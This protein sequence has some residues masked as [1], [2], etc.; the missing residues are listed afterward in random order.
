VDT[1]E[2]DP[3]VDWLNEYG[4]TPLSY[5]LEKVSQ[6][7][8]IIFGEVHEF[9]NYLSFLN[10]N[11]PYLYKAGVRVIAMEICRKSDDHLLNKL[12]IANNY[13]NDLALEIER[14]NLW[15]V[16]GFKDYWDILKAVWAFNSG[17]DSSQEKINIIGLETDADMPS[18]SLVLPSEDRKAGPFYEKFRIFRTAGSI[19]YV[20]YRDELMA[21][22][23]E[24]QIISKNKKGIVWVGSAHSYLNFKQPFSQKGRMA[25]IL[26]KKYGDKVYQIFLHYNDYSKQIASLLESSVQRSKFRQI[27]FDVLNSPFGILRDSSSEYFRDRPKISFSDIARGYLYLNPIDSLV[28]C[29]FIQDFVSKEM[30]INEKPFF[31]TV[32]G[33]SFKNVSELNRFYVHKFGN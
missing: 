17:L 23:I 24:D 31:E 29:K 12:V 11:I 3:Y 14:H 4:K 25:Y 20:A 32:A 22:E 27:G 19:P 10:D 2:I 26:H 21:K 5:I 28:H 15:L 6:H 30:F 7:Q 16:W 18:I 1:S 8:V 13:D 9:S 33:R